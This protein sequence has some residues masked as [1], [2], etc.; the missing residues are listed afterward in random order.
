MPCQRTDTSC[1]TAHR[2]DLARLRRMLAACGIEHH[3]V[4]GLLRL[5]RSRTTEILLAL[6][7]GAPPPRKYTTALALLFEEATRRLEDSAMDL[8]ERVACLGRDG[9][10]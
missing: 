2:S 6:E 3:E 7:A 8:R 1:G 5:S 9:I 4:A 10:E